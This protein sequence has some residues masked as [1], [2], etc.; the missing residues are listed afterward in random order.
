MT[1]CSEFVYFK[2]SPLNSLLVDKN[3][4]YGILKYIKILT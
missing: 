1:E 2:C 3:N 4:I